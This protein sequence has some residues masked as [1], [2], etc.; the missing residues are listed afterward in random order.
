MSNAFSREFLGESPTKKDQVLVFS[1]AILVMGVIG[2]FNY[3]QLSAMPLWKPVL[4]L[5]M[6]LDIVSGAVANF[7]KST[8]LYYRNNN[9]RVTF[10]LI[11]FIHIGLLVLAVGHIWYCLAV[12]AF[13]LAGALIVNFTKSLK[14][15]E[16]TAAVVVNLGI[17]LFYVVFP[18][19]QILNWLPGIL[20]MKLVFGFAINRE[21]KSNLSSAIKD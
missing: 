16:I 19:P 8:Q 5:L 15:Q 13:T 20:L 14:Q 21:S 6:I 11:H 2:Y 4:F 17:I 10:L 12:L 3:E 7:T 9:K 18:A 1:I